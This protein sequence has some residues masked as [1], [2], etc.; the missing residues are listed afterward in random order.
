MHNTKPKVWICPHCWTGLPPRYKGK[1]CLD[2]TDV[3]AKKM[4]VKRINISQK[5]KPKSKGKTRS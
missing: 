5:K 1:L 3:E 2:C 4:K